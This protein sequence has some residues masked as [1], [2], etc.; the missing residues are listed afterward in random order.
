MHEE[1]GDRGLTVFTVALDRSAEDAR[2]YIERARPTHPSVIDVEHVVA[3]L[4][5]MINVPTVVWIDEAGRIA[6]PNSVDFGTD[7]FR[8]F[9]GRESGPFLEAVRAWVRDGALPFPRGEA[10]ARVAPPTEAEQ[11]ARAEF[12]VAWHLHRRGAPEAAERHFERAAALSPHDWTIRRGSMPIRGIDPMGPRFFDLY[13]EWE[14]AGKPD[15][16]RLARDRREED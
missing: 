1:L 7:L 6:R 16:E 10:E 13:R 14:A 8:A 4:Y 11:E 5:A 3:D 9:H 2:P 12:A 15:Y